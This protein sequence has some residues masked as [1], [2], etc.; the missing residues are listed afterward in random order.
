M[1][2]VGR[3]RGTSPTRAT[4]WSS[5]LKRYDASSPP[6]TSTSAPGTFGATDRSP[7]TTTSATTPTTTVAVLVSPSDPSQD[8]SS[9]NEFEPVTSVPVIFGSSPMTTSMAAPNRKP[10]T[11]A[12]DRN[13][14]T[15]P[16]LNTAS[17]RKS[18]PEARVSPATN[19]ATSPPLVSPAAATALA[20]TAASPELGPMEICRQVPNTAYSRAA[21]AAA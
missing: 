17:R 1:A 4:P 18:R 5:R 2:K 11:T 21:A 7:K 14:A 16:I 9:W 13:C 12:R 19:A 20:A 3:P 6:T 10:V 15:H 8:R